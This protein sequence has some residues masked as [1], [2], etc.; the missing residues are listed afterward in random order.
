M[1]A[2]GAAFAVALVLALAGTP[3]AAEAA[4]RFG[5]VDRPDARLKRH[6]GPVPY[7][8]GLAVYAAFLL[9]LSLTFRFDQRVLGLLFAG[10]V[11]VTL[12][13]IDDLG[14]LRPFSKLA[15][16]TIACLV[17]VK[18]GVSIQ[19]AILPAW[20]NLAL[21]LLWVLA[22]V[23]AVNFLDI[24]DGL[25]AGVCAIAAFFLL[26]VAWRNGEFMVVRLA[27][28]LA[29]SLVGFLWYNF[30][31]AR[32]Y[33]GDTGSLFLGVTLAGLAMVGRY[34][35]VN[36][37]AYFSPLLILG[38]PLFEIFFTSVVRWMRGRRPWIGSPDHVALRLRALGLGPVPAVGVLYLVS[39]ALGYLA[40]WN[41]LL[42]ITHSFVLLLGVAA[43]G[44]LVAALLARVRVA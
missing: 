17:L 42:P 25:A 37:I 31:P 19:I 4:R 7:L 38:V 33:L 44:V 40:L 34:A 36:R 15:G 3:R 13:L 5:I 11:A 6:A 2:I 16:E 1:I 22:V 10:S 39:I 24:M 32:I 23:N 21:T 30:H 8:G 41:L 12:G 9:A 35:E 14:A 18:S 20:L 26:V 28:A 27:A 29:G 43:A